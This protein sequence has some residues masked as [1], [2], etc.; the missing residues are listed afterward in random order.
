MLIKNWNL[1]I[2][3][4]G[5]HVKNTKEAGHCKTNKHLHFIAKKIYLNDLLRKSCCA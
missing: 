5:L 3:T 1:L 4:T 2:T